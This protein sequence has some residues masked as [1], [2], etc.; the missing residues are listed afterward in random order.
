MVASYRITKLGEGMRRVVL[1]MMMTVDGVISDVEQ[2]LVRDDD[3]DRDFLAELEAIDTGLAGYR[4]YRGMVGYW[5]NV[6]QNPLAS[7]LEVEMAHAL[8][9]MHKVVFSTTEEELPWDNSQLAVV[10]GD[11]DVVEAVT[12][13][14][15]QSGKDIELTGGA[16]TAQR[17]ARLRLIDEYRLIINPVAAGDGVRLFTER[18]RLE[19]VRSK[20]YESGIVSLCYRGVEEGRALTRQ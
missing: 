8:A 5:A 4:A 19:L 12:K 7:A 9:H 14:K 20:T 10:K 16:A 13:L 3:V 2:W 15:L 17:F 18:I 11:Q 1:R 6:P